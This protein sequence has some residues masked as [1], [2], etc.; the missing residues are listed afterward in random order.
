[1][2]AAVRNFWS[3]LNGDADIG[4]SNIFWLTSAI[5]VAT[6]CAF[7]LYGSG[8]EA[9]NIA[10]L[11]LNVPM[12]LGLCLLWGYGGVLSF[13]QVAYFG[14]A[15][16]TY[17]IIAGNLASITGGTI[18]AVIGG[19]LVAGVLAAL[20][21][22]FVFY[23]RVSAWIVPILTLVLSLLLETFLGLTAGY[24]WRVGS[25]QLGG[26]NGMNGIPSFKIGTLVFQDYPFFYLTLFVVIASYVFARVLVNSH[27]GQVIVAMREDLLRTE[28]LGY[29]VRREQLFLFVIGALLAAVSGILYVEWG[30]YITPSAMGLRAAALPVIWVAVGGRDS[31]TAAVIATFL[32][33]D[34][35]YQLASAGNRYGLV[36]VGMLLVLVMLFTPEGVIAGLA[37]WHPREWG[38]GLWRRAFRDG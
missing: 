28:M 11:L 36:I 30:N 4:H 15:G 24:A 22:Y 2:K 25:V 37:R 32:L 5:L 8:Y 16:Y 1:M 35:T 31:L 26:Y 17:G 29:D 19:M 23:G 9:T 20:F 6:F 18:I 34:L 7:P 27:W 3:K 12:A 13:G 10:Y 38:R 14:V 33:N 21:G